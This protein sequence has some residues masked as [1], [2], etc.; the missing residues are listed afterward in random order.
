MKR[1]ICV[2][3]SLLICLAGSSF[4]LGRVNAATVQD[5]EQ[6]AALYQEFQERFDAVKK[7]EDIANAG[8]SVIEEQLFPVILESFGEEELS[9][10]PAMDEKYHR[11]MLFLA[12]GEG[13]I[14]Y[15]THQLET[16]YLQKGMMSQPTREL[17]AVS[18]QDVN[19]DG[20]TDIILITKCINDSG[21]YAGK[22]YKVGDVLFQGEGTFYRDWRVSDK[23]NRFSMNKSANCIASFVR[24][25]S[26]T[27]V[28]YTA[29]TLEDLLDSGFSIIEEQCYWRNFE[30]LGR[31]QVVPGII[32][33]SEYD[34]FMI[35]LVN[36]QGYIVWSFDPM[37]DSDNL[38]A[39]KGITGK[40]LDGDGMKDL[41][42]LAKYSREGESGE[43]EVHM[44]CAIYYQRTSGFDM[45]T[46]FE[47]TYQ[48]TEEDTME[49]LVNKIREY[50]GWQ[51]LDNK[52][53]IHTKS[54]TEDV[55]T[56]SEYGEEEVQ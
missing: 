21:N 23:I 18:F 38:Y 43:L 15:K 55:Y 28:L 53:V 14:V 37:G 20:R 46:E 56:V 47:K 26:S 25:D 11:L 32:R 10:L 6:T 34:I 12:D 19:G 50:W 3:L 45:D 54:D 22:T 35:Y 27:E 36:E 39:L 42:V 16:N 31:L 8:F 33:I 29:T 30:K 44:D 1:G 52:K 41:V 24:G 7:R 4:F 13:N 9:F 48:C 2:V 49:Q 40:D 51:V 17:T 5:D